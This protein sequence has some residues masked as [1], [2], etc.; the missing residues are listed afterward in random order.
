MKQKPVNDL[1]ASVTELASILGVGK[2]TAY[3]AVHAGQIP[4]VRV[5]KRYLIP[6]N[7]INE[8]LGTLEKEKPTETPAAPHQRVIRGGARLSQL[9]FEELTETVDALSDALRDIGDFV[10]RLR[11][12]RDELMRAT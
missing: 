10:M 5:G 2:N 3:R 11:R 12:V 6:R 4:S 1:A 8:M 7:V 9:Q